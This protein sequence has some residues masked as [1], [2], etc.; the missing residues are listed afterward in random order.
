MSN[1]RNRAPDLAG[2]IARLKDHLRIA[3]ERAD[4]ARDILRRIVDACDEED[5]E[6]DSALIDEAR[7]CLDGA[8]IQSPITD[9]AIDAAVT[10]SGQDMPLA[11][12]KCDG[13]DDGFGWYAHPSHPG[14][15]H[16]SCAPSGSFFYLHGAATKKR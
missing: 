4:K 1:K 2:Q 6:I 11:C 10:K 3:D 5:G 12:E 14:V 16:R 7:K 9:A 8:A 15:R 13:P